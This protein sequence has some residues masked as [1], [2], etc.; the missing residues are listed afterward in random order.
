MEYMVA[1][2]F[3]SFKGS[4]QFRQRDETAC[5]GELINYGKYGVMA[6]QIGQ[7]GDEV[8]SYMGPRS[9]WCGKWV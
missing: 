6:L 5:F 7:I 2:Q 9:A 3:S 4:G 1:E 8:N